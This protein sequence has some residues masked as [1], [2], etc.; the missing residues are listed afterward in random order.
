MSDYPDDFPPFQEEPYGASDADLAAERFQAEQDS[1]EFLAHE[2]M[3]EFDDW[4]EWAEDYRNEPDIPFGYG[5]DDYDDY[6]DD[7]EDEYSMPYDEIVEILDID[8]IV[9]NEGCLLK[10]EIHILANGEEVPHEYYLDIGCDDGQI[11]F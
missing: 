5:G 8:I 11:P 7:D 9:T 6:W 10:K 3:E 2:A 1:E 4:G